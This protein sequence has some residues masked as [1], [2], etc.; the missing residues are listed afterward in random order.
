VTATQKAFSAFP[1]VLVIDGRRDKTE[2]R[3]WSLGTPINRN[4]P[5]FVDHMFFFQKGTYSS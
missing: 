1:V 5:F 3:G 4:T 2:G